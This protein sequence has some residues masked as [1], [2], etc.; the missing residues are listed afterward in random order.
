[1]VAKL[2]GLFVSA[3]IFDREAAESLAAISF[4]LFGVF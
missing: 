4:Q 2:P 3:T 1:L